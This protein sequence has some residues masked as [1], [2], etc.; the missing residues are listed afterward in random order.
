MAELSAATPVPEAV[1]SDLSDVPEIEASESPED[2]GEE[3]DSEPGRDFR[4]SE[5]LPGDECDAEASYLRLRPKNERNF[6]K[7]FWLSLK[8]A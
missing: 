3:D 8:T 6:K 2:L 4:T 7:P 5:D 1:D